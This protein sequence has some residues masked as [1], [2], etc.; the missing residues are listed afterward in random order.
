[1][2]LSEIFTHLSSGELSQISLGK[3]FDGETPEKNY[4]Y[5]ISSINL[6][7]TALHTRFY[8]KEG[9]LKF[10]LTTE[11]TTYDLGR[12][13][14]LKI[15]QVFTLEGEEISVNDYTNL[16]S[17]FTPSLG[18]L[19]VPEVLINKGPDLPEALITDGLRV[20]Y[21]ANH[22]II[23]MDLDPSTYEVVLPYSHL[24]ALLYYVASR[25][26]NPIGMINE[27]HSGNSWAAKY[28]AECL[29]LEQHNIQ[30]DPRGSNA[31]FSQGGWV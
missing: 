20:V 16:Y 4:G 15:E 2:K 9:R 11:G 22:E 8:L 31:R 23:P 25:V 28:E 30:V 13:D 3:Q 17:C 14:I 6:A 1:M 26:H 10:L 24:T 19:T 21:R 12:D 5:L 29:R 18:S 27:F 7:L